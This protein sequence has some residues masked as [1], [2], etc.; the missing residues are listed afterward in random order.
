M[1]TLIIISSVTVVP[2][3]QATVFRGILLQGR[4]MTDGSVLGTFTD[5]DANTRLSSCSTA[6]VSLFIAMD[7]C[8]HVS[9][10]KH[11]LVTFPLIECYYSQQ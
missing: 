6:E 8:L 9:E 3:D 10:F 5:V 4:S 1:N 7:L 2:M 11:A